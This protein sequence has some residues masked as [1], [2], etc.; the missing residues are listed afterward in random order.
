MADERQSNDAPQF[1]DLEREWI[2]AQLPELRRSASD[3]S[4]LKWF[5]GAAFV[6]G[7]AAHAAGYLLK[8]SAPSEPLGLMAE[9]LYAL[10]LALSANV[11]DRTREFGV[12]HAIG[13]RPRVVRRIVTAEGLFIAIASCLVAILPTV[14]LTGVLGALLGDLFLSAPLPF[15]ISWVAV[16]IWLAI[17]LL[18]AVLATEAAA[19]RASRMTVREALAYL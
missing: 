6:L 13:A 9:L 5:L 7:L 10:G 2:A 12:M 1:N 19:T 18:G 11:L 15:R 14:L 3:A 8:S 17:V 16:V 4:I